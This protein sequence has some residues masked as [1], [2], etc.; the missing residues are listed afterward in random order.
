MFKEFKKYERESR[1][2]EYK[3]LNINLDVNTYDKISS[4]SNEYSSKIQK[5]IIS[6]DSS[7]RNKINF[8]SD[9][10]IFNE[11]ILKHIILNEKEKIVCESSEK[12]YPNITEFKLY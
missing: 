10:S 1:K 4:T 11:N 8:D 3:K 7:S 6:S 9:E 5:T 12:L 2:K